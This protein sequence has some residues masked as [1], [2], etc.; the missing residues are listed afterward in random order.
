MKKHSDDGPDWQDQRKK[1]IGLGESSLRKSYYPELREKMAELEKKNEELQAAYEELTSGEEELRQNYEELSA[2]EHD[3]RESEEKYRN[4]IE[5]TFDGVVIHQNRI[6]VFA[7]QT[8]ARMIGCASP[9]DLLGRSIFDVAHPDYRE[10]VTD[11]S[12]RALESVQL[13][14][15]EQ[16]I[17]HDGTAFDVEVVATPIVWEGSPAVQVAFRDMTA[18]NLAEVAIAEA[19]KLNRAVVDNAPLG[20]LIFR[21]TGQCI[22]ANATAAKILG[23]TIEQLKTQ[24]FH[25]LRPWQQHGLVDLAEKTLVSGKSSSV[26][27]ELTTTFGVHLWLNFILTPFMSGGELH[28]LAMFSDFTEQKLAEAALRETEEKIRESEEFLR[29]VITGAK[30]GIVVYDRELR[31]TLWN[32]FMEEMTGIQAVDVQGKKTV[33]I[34]PFLKE[35]GIDILIKQALAGTIAESSDFRFF[36]HSTGKKGWVKGIYSPNYDAHGTLIGVI[37]IIRDITGQKTAEDALRQ[38]EQRYRT[39]VETTDTGFVIVDTGGRVVDANQK[40]VQMTGHRELAEIVGRSVVEWTADYEKERNAK[41]VEQCA[42]D[43]FIRNFV[44]DYVNS[45]GTITPIEVNATVVPYGNVPRILTLCRDITDRRMAEKALEQARKKLGLLN[46][47][48]FQDIQ[49]TIFALSAYLQL[50]NSNRE[51][52]KAKSFAEKEAFLIHKIVSSLNFAKNYQDMGIHPPRWQNVN[53]V[54]LYAISHLDSLKVSRDVRVDGL[55]CY[56]DP[57]LEKVFFNLIENIFLHGQKATEISLGYEK[58]GEDFFLILADNGVGIPAEEKQKI[59][60]RGYGKNTGLGLFLVRE[61]LSITGIT[62]REN[63]TEGAGARFEML[64]PKG[65]YRFSDTK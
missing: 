12:S 28:L 49:S 5:N 3:L 65:S 25:T 57:L 14:R 47:V 36:I 22:S 61:I 13:P 45:S 54:F 7:N 9:A 11:R 10:I 64:I 27:A 15:H 39:L 2:K 24:N 37:G 44:V 17:H 34:F 16:F 35:Q 52:A 30:E 20:I 48:I 40:Y 31:I 6:I 33:E 4:L 59:F 56:A 60:E 51:E 19:M 41:A 55:E 38:S 62:I 8:A 29:T 50:A 1:I 26:L 46:T 53:Q 43:G 58:R 23:G 63:G 18:Q 42:R 21:A 32:R